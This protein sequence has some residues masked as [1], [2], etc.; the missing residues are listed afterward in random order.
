MLNEYK[1]PILELFG[2]PKILIFF[3]LSE[4]QFL[5]PY[6]SLLRAERYPIKCSE[7]NS[8]VNVITITALKLIHFSTDT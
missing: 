6:I 2:S 8:S 5:R 1:E 7:V 3:F 4:L